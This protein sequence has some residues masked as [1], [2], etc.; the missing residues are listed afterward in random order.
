MSSHFFNI[1]QFIL[2]FIS[3]FFYFFVNP[4]DKYVKYSDETSLKPNQACVLFFL[5]LSWSCR[6]VGV[7]LRLAADTIM[8]SCFCQREAE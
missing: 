1:K 4:K 8:E 6:K 7:T 2:Y 5:V 3:L